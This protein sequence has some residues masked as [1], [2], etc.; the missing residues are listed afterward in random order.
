MNL[1]GYF[2]GRDEALEPRNQQTKVSRL[3]KHEM[4]EVLDNDPCVYELRGIREGRPVRTKI[5]NWKDYPEGVVLDRMIEDVE[6][7]TREW[8]ADGYNVYSTFNGIS[9]DFT[10]KN[11]KDKDITYRRHLFIDI[12]R[13]ARANCPATNE[14]VQHAMDL[15]RQIKDFMSGCGWNLPLEVMSGNGVHLYFYLGDMPNTKELGNQA[16]DLLNLLGDKFDNS[17]VKVDRSV[18]NAS[19]IS[20]VIGTTAKKG[21]ISPGRPFREVRILSFAEP[22]GLKLPN[23]DALINDTIDELCPRR[24]AHVSL[25]S[26]L[27]SAKKQITLDDTP[28]NRALISELLNRVSSDCDRAKWRN[29]VWSIL[30]TG[31]TG[32]E[33]LASDWSIKS[34][35]YTETDFNNLIRDY[36]PSVEGRGGGITLGTL[37]YHARRSEDDIGDSGHERE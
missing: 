11:V 12:D 14:E 5:F 30:S 32:A 31:I 19:R 28:N 25:S 22:Y 2:N 17:H 16:R 4:W 15:S 27:P 37:R 13:A 3:Y 26:S 10:G 36:D 34:D 1:E 33:D 21:T 7:T 24:G 8:D 23:F 18:Y 20:K 9:E 6:S 35:R 29:I